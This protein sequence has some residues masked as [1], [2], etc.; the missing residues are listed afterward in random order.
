MT[1]KF[2]WQIIDNASVRN[3]LA[4]M[5]NVPSLTAHYRMRKGVRHAIFQ[6]IERLKIHIFDEEMQCFNSKHV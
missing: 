3:M 6:N 2:R 4:S 1:A 5:Q